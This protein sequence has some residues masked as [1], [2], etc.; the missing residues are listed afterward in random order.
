[1]NLFDLARDETT[2]EAGGGVKGVA[3]GLVTQ[4]KDPDGR[5]RVKV[6]FPWHSNSQESYWARIAVPMAGNDRGTVFLP[7][8]DDEVLVAFERE[9]IRFPYV[10][11]SLWNGAD[12]PPEANLDGKNDKRIIK[13]RKGHRLLFDDGAKGLVQLELNDKKKLS[14]DDDGIRLDD[15]K[16]NSVSIQSASGAITIE[17]KGALTLKGTTISIE[18][19]G[20]LQLKSSATVSVRGSLVTIN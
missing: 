10:V 20:T 9:D 19:S 12:K 11:G 3:T 14:I 2:L 4:N 17:A 5:H 7:E 13:S 18:A 8:V 15:A 1:V 6:R 16:G